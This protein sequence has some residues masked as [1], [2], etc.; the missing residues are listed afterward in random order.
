[1]PECYRKLYNDDSPII[2]FYP[3]EVKLDINGAR[4]AWMGVNLLPFIDRQRLVAAMQEA[5]GNGSKLTPHE[6]ER[7]RRSGDI[8]LFFRRSGATLKSAMVKQLMEGT[9]GDQAVEASFKNKD[10]ISGKVKC[11]TKGQLVKYGH[12]IDKSCGQLIV[13][14]DNCECFLVHYEH[15]EYAAH[16]C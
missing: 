9:M 4:Y 15:P 5:D 6:K 7:N 11:P 10:A 16:L 3:K 8:R 13:K 14:L 1:M 2:D 12:N